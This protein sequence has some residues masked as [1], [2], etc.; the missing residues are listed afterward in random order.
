MPTAEIDRPIRYLVVGAGWIAQAAVLPA[1]EHARRARLDGIV[2]GDPIKRRELS[3]RYGVPSYD[4]DEY[5]AVLRRGDVDAVYIALPNTMH[6]D[7][8]ERAAA[9]GVHVLCEKPMATTEEDCQAMIDACARAHVKLM[10]AYRLHFEEA[11]LR[12]VEIARS[13]ELGDVRLFESAITQRTDEGIRLDPKLGGGALFDAGVYCV[14]AARYIFGDEPNVVVGFESDV[15]PQFRGV[16][17]T[18]GAILRFPRGQVATFIASLGAART[19]E[20]RVIGTRGDLLV[21]PAYVFDAGLAHV[22]TRDGKTQVR[23]FPARDQFAPELDYFAECIRE[24]R[25]PEP[26]GEEGLADVRVMVAIKRSIAT[27]QP[28]CL[29]EF[30]RSM[31]PTLAQQIT[32]DAPPPSPPLVHAEAAA[33]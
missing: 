3:E 26:N 29:P 23:C 18:T 31:R 33:K 7:Y 9:A 2:S 15:D 5:D 8:T 21:D 32:V 17:E 28:V 19:S 11:N 4:Y 22:L 27:A 16:D 12:A 24:D 20:Y 14:N 30:R 13:G 10:I 6:R 25:E 1:F